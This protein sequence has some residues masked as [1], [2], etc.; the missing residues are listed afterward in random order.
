VRR[1][2]GGLLLV[3]WTVAAI[4]GWPAAAGA[5][6][7]TGP[8]ETVDNQLTTTF[9]NAAT[10]FHYIGR[11]HGAGD[12]NSDPPYM[13]KMVS[14]QPAGMRFDTDVPDRCSASDL[15]LAVLGASACPPES[16]LGGGSA[17]GK[18]MGSTSKLEVDFL[19]NTGEQILVVRSP[20]LASVSRGKIRPD[21]SVEF[22]SPTC[23]PALSPP[24]CP[25]D[26]ALQ[27]GSDITVPTYIRSRDGVVRSYMT[28]PPVCPSSRHWDLPIRFWWADG[29]VDTVVVEQLCTPA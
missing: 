1:R 20:L 8:H 9:P 23:F 10:G 25:I 29:S 3:S 26:D 2:A 14:Y 22:A 18:F 28:T 19:N 11:Y 4:A 6:P 16:R 17:D 12:P 5:A 27:L 24:G 21:G 13:R 7:V 15:E